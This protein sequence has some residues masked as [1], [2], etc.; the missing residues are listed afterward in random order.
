MFG[1]DQEIIFFAL[2][3]KEQ[4]SCIADSVLVELVRSERR[5]YFK[6]KFF[7]SINYISRFWEIFKLYSNISRLE[8]KESKKKRMMKITISA[9]IQI[10]IVVSMV[11][12]THQQGWFGFGQNWPYW[13]QQQQQRKSNSN[14]LII[15]A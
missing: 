4:T 1:F 13:Q 10:V 2:K 5:T 8:K 14:C 7:H 15:S 9:F 6:L 12:Q 11:A 3:Q